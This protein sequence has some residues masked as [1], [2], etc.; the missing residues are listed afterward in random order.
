MGF[1]EEECINEAKK[2]IYL[3]DFKS[4]SPCHYRR[5]MKLGIFK[6]IKK[7][8][9]SFI[10]YWSD[11]DLIDDAKKYNSKSKWLK[12]SKKAYN[13]ATLRKILDKCTN[14]MTESNNLW[15]DED[16][17]LD[18]KKYKTIMSWRKNSCG[19]YHTAFKRGILKKCCNHMKKSIR[20]SFDEIDILNYVKTLYPNA[21]NK[22][23]KNNSISPS[24]SSLELDIYVPELNKG[25]EFNGTYWHGKG[26]KRN[27]V[28]SPEEYHKLK[29]AFFKDIGIDYLEIWEEDWKND[30][31]GCIKIIDSFLPK[32]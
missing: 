5:S 25:I 10:K 13:I 14:H 30:K 8:L 27:W 28:D 23:F 6:E 19:A 17:I 1:T 20:V 15:K 18:A 32:P 29:R 16:I 31:N 24:F 9:I 11:Q 22:R 2:Y 12:N 3:K 26:F 4:G 7:N 21:V